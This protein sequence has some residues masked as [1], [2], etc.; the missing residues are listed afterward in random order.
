MSLRARAM[1]AV[2]LTIGFYVLAIG[3][4]AVLVRIVFIPNVPGRVLAFCI[5]GAGA[6][7]ISIIPR[8]SRFVAPGPRLNPRRPASPVCRARRRGGGGGRGH[9][10]GGLCDPRDE[11]GRAAARAAEGDGSWTAAHAGDDRFADARGAGARVRPLLRWRHS[12]GTMDLPHSR[13]HR[14]HAERAVANQLLL[15]DAVSLVWPPVPARDASR[16]TPARA[17]G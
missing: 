15:A 17:G 12:P 3:L 8:P 14:A 11:R 1:L 10:R 16:L 5:V 4:I 13:D 9:A 7:A 2:A 6:I